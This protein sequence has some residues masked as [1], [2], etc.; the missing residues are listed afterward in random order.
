MQVT[1]VFSNAGE[2]Q[3][4]QFGGLTLA[5][6]LL[7]Q[8]K[9]TPNAVSYKNKQQNP[10]TICAAYIALAKSGLLMFSNEKELHICS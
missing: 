3:G 7:I 10:Y 9:D 5:S 6:D 2:K 4:T 8:W 1:K